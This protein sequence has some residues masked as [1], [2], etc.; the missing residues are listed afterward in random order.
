VT[1]NDTTTGSPVLTSAGHLAAVRAAGEATWGLAA[2]RLDAGV[3]ACPEWQVRDLVYHLGNVAYYIRACVDHGA[4]EP[5]FTDA[6]MP[7]DDAVIAWA[8]QEWDLA[9]DSLAAADPA[10]AAWNWSDE[11]HVVSFWPRCLTHEAYVHGW[12]AAD[13]VD[14]VLPIP[15]DVAVDGVDEILAVHVPAGVR[16]GRRFPVAGRAEV[17]CTDTGHRWLIDT[18]AD[19]VVVTT[20]DDGRPVDERIEATAEQLYLE[21]WGR[22]ALPLSPIRRAWADQLAANWSAS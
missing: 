13:A 9:V 19:S 18:T 3:P 7:S 11:P 14:G 21:L 16:S 10:A 17:R 1:S 2:G 22:V 5:D 6:P 12:D 4:G 20:A 15:A 8:E